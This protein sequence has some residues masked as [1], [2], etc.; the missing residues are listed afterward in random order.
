MSM[1]LLGKA[2]EEGSEGGR[3]GEGEE[4]E[5]EGDR[6]DDAAVMHCRWKE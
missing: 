6:S 5:G 2:E 3:A 1:P 4:E